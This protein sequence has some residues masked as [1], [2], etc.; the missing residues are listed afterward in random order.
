MAE[1]GDTGK[2][3]SSSEEPLGMRA[4]LIGATGAIGECLLGELLTSKHI[5]KVVSLGRRSATVPSGY[6]V[7][8]KAEEDSGR[9]EQHVVDFEN[10]SSETFGAHFKDKD[11]FFCTLGTTRHA[12]GSAAA[13]RHVDFDFVINC[14]KVAKEANVPHVL[15][16]SSERANA[17]SWFLYMKVK[18]EV[19]E[20]LKEMQYPKTSIFRPGLLDRGAKKRFLEKA[21]G[22]IAQSIPVSTVAKA[23][24]VEAE[25]YA[26]NKE[27][28]PAAITYENSDILAL[29]SAS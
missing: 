24:L 7:D 20:S 21:Y 16:V 6:S 14:A 3:I 2:Q 5:S 17:S 27:A 12:A 11:V 26:R 25:K 10:I 9:L 23:M 18:G 22:W 1:G 29:L 19:E 28:D 15:Y 13:F 4:V 8:Q